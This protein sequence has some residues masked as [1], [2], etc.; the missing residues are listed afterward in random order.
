[1]ARDGFFE[2]F[3][4][5]TGGV[6][7]NQPGAVWGDLLRT[8]D[9]SGLTPAGDGILGD[10]PELGG[11]LGGH[12]LFRICQDHGRSSLKSVVL[13]QGALYNICAHLSRFCG[14]NNEQLQ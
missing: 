4:L 10:A 2:A 12:E 9:F 8:G 3:G 6:P 1:M 11:F 13:S 14:L 5:G 7:G